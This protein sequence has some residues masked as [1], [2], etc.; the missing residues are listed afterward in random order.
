M[1]K[2]IAVLCMAAAAGALFAGGQ[3]EVNDEGVVVLERGDAA[4]NSFFEDLEKVEVTGRVKFESPVPELVSGGQ[5][6]TLMIPGMGEYLSY[7]SEGDSITVSGYILDEDF[8][9]GRRGGMA[10]GRM[11]GGMR[12][13]IDEL[14][15]NINLFVETVEIDGTV[16]ELPKTDPGSHRG[17]AQMK[18][19]RGEGMAPNRQ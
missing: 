10:G 19:G 5:D 7:I 18:S 4:R 1:K 3:Q 14:E 8:M 6:Y 2:L 11:G 13:D 15:G 17:G 9:P 12:M 16:Y